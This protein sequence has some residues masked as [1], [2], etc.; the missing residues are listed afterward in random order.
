MFI[1]E[2]ISTHSVLQYNVNLKQLN[3]QDKSN[4]FKFTYWPYCLSFMAT[5]A[6]RLYSNWF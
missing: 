5:I 3:K 6:S 4:S 1:T 2:Y